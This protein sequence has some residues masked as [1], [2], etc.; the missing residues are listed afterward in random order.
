[1]TTLMG[2]VAVMRL[3]LAWRGVAGTLRAV[4]PALNPRRLW[5]IA[6][7]K[8]E[9]RRMAGP[10]LLAAFSER[11]PRPFFVEIG[12][13][14]G[15]HDDHLRPFILSGGWRGLMVE[16]VPWIFKKLSANYGSVDGVTPVNVA[17]ADRD[18]ELPFYHLAEPTGE[19]A[20]SLPEWADGIGSFSRESVL[21]HARVIP[22][23]DRLVVD[24]KVPVLTF[25]SLCVRHAVERVDLVLVDTEGYDREVLESIDLRRWQPRLVVYEHYH[26]SADE[27]AGCRAYLEDAGYETMEEGFDTFCLATSEEDAL[28]ATWRRLRPAVR[29]VYAYQEPGA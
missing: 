1:M 4:A 17:I 7:Y 16:P 14:D 18:G 2:S 20:D 21:S 28:T 13:N 10:K 11:Y 8:R 23:V 24:T 15:D 12:A 25:D 22:D 9:Q 5:R 6:K 29:A 26:L 3:F 27:Q 19:D